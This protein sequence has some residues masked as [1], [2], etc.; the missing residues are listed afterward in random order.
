MPPSERCVTSTDD[1]AFHCA[2]KGTVLA[3][4]LSVSKLSSNKFSGVALSIVCERCG[5]LQGRAAEVAPAGDN[6][7][8]RDARCHACGHDPT[9]PVRTDEI[10]LR[11]KP[12]RR[13]AA[14]DK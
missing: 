6:S 14:R 1:S 9:V 5:Q 8:R 10:K 7:A 12:D 11:R 3:L 13:A 2:I 4:L